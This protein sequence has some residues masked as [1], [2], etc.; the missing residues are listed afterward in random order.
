[1]KNL[2]IGYDLP[3][4]QKRKVK[5]ISQRV[6]D[7]KN[8]MGTII[9]GE[10]YYDS[11]QE[12]DLKINKQGEILKIAI[13][14]NKD[15]LNL[16]EEHQYSAGKKI[17]SIY[18]NKKGGIESNYI[19]QNT[20][21]DNHLVKQ[22]KYSHDLELISTKVYIYNSD[23]QNTEINLYDKEGILKWR[24][25]EHFEDGSIEPHKS[26][27]YDSDGRHT[28]SH[29]YE[30]YE[31]GSLKEETGEN[32][33]DISGFRTIERYDEQGRLTFNS[34][35]GGIWKR[36]Y[37]YNETSLVSVEYEHRNKLHDIVNF[38]YEF[39]LFGNWV[40]RNHYRNEMPFA[41]TIRHLD[42]Y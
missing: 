8:R 17:K 27:T 6:F 9:L 21:N 37:K 19:L 10:R 16:I 26:L 24:V 29:Y 31:N 20:W 39:D 7:L 15:S 32:T 33:D 40:V 4:S 35:V 34:V 1:M 14:D 2:Q 12:F 23:D 18:T 30:Y 11:D 3:N 42:Y 5:R 41:R 13:A 36:T 22:E 28:H 25:I 38:E